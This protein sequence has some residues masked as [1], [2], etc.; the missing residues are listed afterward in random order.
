MATRTGGAGGQGG[1][2]GAPT[3]LW[4]RR[5]AWCKGSLS[6]RA[7]SG[8][9]PRSRGLAA[10][11]DRRLDNGARVIVTG[12][13]QAGVVAVQLWVAAGTSAERADEHGCAHLLEHMS[14][15]PYPTGGGETDLA[16]AIEE[17]GGDVNAFTSHDE[18]VFHATVPADAG[19]EAVGVLLD[20]VLRS[21]IDPEELARERQVVLEEIKQYA[22]EPGSEAMQDLVGLLF[23]GDSYARP[24]LGRASE[25]RRHDAAVLRRFHRDVY[26]GD[27]LCLVVAGAPDPA[28]VW[29]IARARLGNAPSRSRRLRR[30]RP[31]AAAR[32]AVRVLRRDVVETTVRLGWA[33]PP[34]GHDEAIA[35]DMLAIALGQGDASRLMNRTRRRQRLVSDA[36]A[37]YLAFARAGAMLVSA[38][39]TA[40]RAVA[41]TQALLAE[42]DEATRMPLDPE[43]FARARAVLESGLVYRYETVQGQAHTAGYFATMTGRLDAEEEYYA[44]IERMN[45]EHVRGAAARHLGVGSCVA[46]LVVPEAEVSVEQAKHMAEQLRGELRRRPSSRRKRAKQRRDGVW[47]ADLACGLRVRAL[48]LPEVP[49]AAGWLI[50]PGGLR[51]E[52]TRYAG[53]ANVAA[54]LLS[55]GTADR[56][57]DAIAREIGGLAA[58]LDGFSGRNSL[59]LQFESLSQ[60]LPVVLARAI[61]C[62]T[63]P[64]FPEQELADERRVAREELDAEADDVTQQAYQGM[65]DALYGKHPYRRNMRGTAE[66]L[67]RITRDVVASTWARDYP[68]GRAVL[69]LA[70]DVDVE[71]VVEQVERLLERVPDGEPPSRMPSWPPSPPRWPKG[72]RRVELE[73]VR[74]QAHIVIG[75]PGVTLDDPATG[76][77]DVLLTVLG[78]QSGRLFHAMREREGLVYNV[79]ATS[80]EGIDA[81]HLTIYAAMS[82]DKRERA[83]RALDGELERIQAVR[84]D[85]AELERAKAW[86]CGQHDAGNQRRARLA[87][88]LAFGEVYQLGAGYFLDYRKRIER[89][90]AAAVQR[91]ARQ[92]L[93]PK[94]RVT[95]LVVK[96]LKRG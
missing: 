48:A 42:V 23:R 21:R 76:A 24:V 90:T 56:D 46:V 15:K 51:L 61:E 26:A 73:R 55:R 16:L 8:T 60:H 91:A 19:E 29:A 94:R 18:T 66:S 83:E 11:L 44:A 71:A 13:R 33:G 52:R 5:A 85:A 81:G 72:A 10:A 47:A 57:G 2:G 34:T 20:A 79:G 78:G 80:V 30:E 62:A 65:L 88:H 68:I 25:V 14:F 22:D 36:N 4:V 32:P 89:V 41:A 59:G 64:S 63:R 82:H 1:T 3:G 96:P 7:K 92:L 93:D 70:G 67:D 75:Y 69:A 40:E 12:G 54:R 49:V 45:P 6:A 84:V 35:L 95:S 53:V 87:S 74:A 86:L 9:A 77:I 58:V 37:A 39:T 43:E 28:R 27:K 50:W 38:Q 31:G 17:L